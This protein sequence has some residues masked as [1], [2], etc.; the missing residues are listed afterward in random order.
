MTIMKTTYFTPNT[1]ASK[2]TEFL[3]QLDAEDLLRSGPRDLSNAALLVLDMQDYFLDPDSHAFVPGAPVIIAGIQR[4]IDRCRTT[5]RPVIFTRHI[6]TSANA[7]QMQNWWHD[8]IDPGNPLAAISDHL[9]VDPSPVIDKSQ[10]DAFYQTGLHDLLRDHGIDTI[11][12]TGV[13]THLCCEATARS[14]FVNNYRVIFPADGSATYNQDFHL[15]SLRNLAHG[16]AHVN[17]IEQLL[18]QL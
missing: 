16:F 5:G 4:L 13:M 2:A 18:G 11:I 6:N 15:S 1:I 3:N 14:A 12:I 17:T 9:A 10:Y 7:G 8:L